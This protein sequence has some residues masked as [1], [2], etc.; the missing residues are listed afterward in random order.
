MENEFVP[1]EQALELKELG[2]DDG[3]LTYYFIGGKMSNYFKKVHKNSKIIQNQPYKFHCTTPFYSQS[4]RW[5]RKK[6][7]LY[8]VIASYFGGAMF[9][10]EDKNKNYH[11]KLRFK[12]HEEA[13]LECLKKLIEIV[14]QNK[15]G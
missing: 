13:E 3:C 1:Y 6:Y 12:T 8:P 15:N 2:F 5:F 4:F 11:N 14:K 7:D 10:I 9:G